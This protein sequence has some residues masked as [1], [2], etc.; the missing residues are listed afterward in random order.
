MR[1]WRVVGR[2]CRA[3]RAAVGKTWKRS[4]A[5]RIVQPPSTTQ[6]AGL[7][8]RR[9]RAF[10]MPVQV[11]QSAPSQKALTLNFRHG[12]GKARSR[13]SD[14]GDRAKLKLYATSY[15]T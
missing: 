7:G 4:A 9:M 14:A 2:P 11:S 8:P 12:V 1:G 15:V 10:L 13:G 3:Q 6:L 5:W